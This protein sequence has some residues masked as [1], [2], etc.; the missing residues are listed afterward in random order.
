LQQPVKQVEVIG[1]KVKTL[2][3]TGGGSKSDWLAASNIAPENWGYAD[4]LVQK[5]SGW[6][7]NAVNKSSGACGLAQ[8]LPCSKLGPNWSNP[9][10]ALNWMNGY[11]GRYGGWEG[12]YKFWLAH[13]WY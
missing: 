8:A 3:Y 11:V 4:F 2:P 1:S 6:N 12:A 5:E 7:P 13:K 9:V 10:V